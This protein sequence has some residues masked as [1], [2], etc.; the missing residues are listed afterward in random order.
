MLE[1]NREATTAAL[2]RFYDL[3]LIDDPGDVDLY[4]AL[5]DR[6]GGR[7][8]E[9]AV[10]SGRVAVPLA[11]AG[12]HVTGVDNDPHMLDRA[13]ARGAASLAGTGGSLKLIEAD[14]VGLALPD[15]AT[16]GFGYLALNSLMT[17]ATRAAQQAAVQALAEQ[18]GPG[19]IAAVDVWL[20]DA[21]DLARYDG[22]LIL[23]WS[24][25][26]PTTGALV[27][28][29]GSAQYDAATGT[30]A[31]TSVFEEGAQGAPAN[32]W[33]RHDRLRLVSADELAGFAEAAGLRIETVGSGYDLDPFGPGSDRAVLVAIRP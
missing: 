28:K 21:E 24:R 12:H 6:A 10:G 26:E 23:E 16:F 4:L 2:A 15:G 17:L 31:L 7:V 27:T 18:L 13:R 22:R 29:T 14:I 32:R 1:S 19:G 5:A 20:P 33:V 9:L 8:L 30:V 25:T 3:D 11:A